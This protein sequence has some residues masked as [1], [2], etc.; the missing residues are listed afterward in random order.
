MKQLSIQTNS[1]TYDVLVGNNLLNEQYIKEFSDRESLLIIDSG[2][3]VHIQKEVSA[4]LKGMSSNFSKI[5][6]EA[7]EDNKSYKTLNLIHD[8]LMELK[9]SRECILFALG[10][11]ITC[12]ITGFAA[13]TYQ[14]GVDFVL[15]PSTLLS[16]VDASV[17]GKTA[18]NHPLGKNMIGAFHQPVKVITDM[19]LLR[20]LS[21]RQI[22][23]GLAEV[24]KHSLLAGDDFFEWLYANFHNLVEIKDEEL[25]ETVYRSIEIKASIVKQDE[26]EQGIRKILNL[27]HTYGHA[28]E[29]YG[30]FGEFS[31]G[32]AVAI[33]MIM[34]AEL[35]YRTTNLTVEE[36]DQIKTV[37]SSIY[38]PVSFAESDVIAIKGLLKHDKKNQSNQ[39]RFVLLQAIGKPV[40]DCLV[41]EEDINES[42]QFYAD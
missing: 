37:F 24:I 39:V 1:K 9:F 15:L 34:E 26:R 31:H 22:N 19:S 17:G 28:I 40:I 25:E 8:K 23:E 38:D 18:I 27:G 32:E 7:T 3:P 42:F 13:S 11:G 21:M 6:I 10:G 5:N 2:V 20:S 30:G 12:D 35:S 4:I 29:L 14:R 16:Q 33:G 41:S 36:R